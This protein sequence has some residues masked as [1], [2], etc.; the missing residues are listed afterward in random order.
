MRR[1]SMT[2]DFDP[3]VVAAAGCHDAEAS[4]PTQSAGDRE[5]VLHR[6][7]LVQR[8]DALRATAAR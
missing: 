3:D 5:I 1:S 8:L 6:A 7:D 4:G 2:A